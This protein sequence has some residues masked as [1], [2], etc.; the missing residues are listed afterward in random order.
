MLVLSRKIGE[1][2]R[3][4]DDI[5]IT[6]VDVR[7]ANGGTVRVGVQ[8]PKNLAVHRQ[9]VYEQIQREGDGDGGQA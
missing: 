2:I 4:G 9:E 6:I 1:V 5:T 3:I 8:A 7:R